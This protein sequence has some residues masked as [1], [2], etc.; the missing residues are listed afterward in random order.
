MS[1]KEQQQNLKAFDWRSGSA[2]VL[3]KEVNLYVGPG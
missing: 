2:L 3:I 1:R